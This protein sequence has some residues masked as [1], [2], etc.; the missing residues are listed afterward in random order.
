MKCP[1]CD[2]DL[3]VTAIIPAEQRFRL[4]I[5]GEGPLLSAETVGGTISGIRKLMQLTAKQGA[6]RVEVF[7]E[8]IQQHD[9]ELLVDFVVLNKPRKHSS[10]E[11]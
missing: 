7:V 4:K 5:A 1:K 3:S 6:V 8:K 2:C 9:G 10:T 11:P